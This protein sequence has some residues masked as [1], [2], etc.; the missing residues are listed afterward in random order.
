MKKAFSLL[1]LIFA[2]VII[3]IIASFAVPKFLDT[4]DS[5]LVSTIKRDL[6]AIT[7]SIQ[8]YH[9]T[10]RDISKI[11][12]AI[13]LNSTNWTVT[14]TKAIFKDVSEDCITVEIKKEN[15]ESNLHIQIDSDVGNLCSKLSDEGIVSITYELF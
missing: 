11:S 1:E 10:N 2:I 13:V 5:A 9:L 15:S 6:S 14:D 8:T 3:A 12:D 4:R 7:T